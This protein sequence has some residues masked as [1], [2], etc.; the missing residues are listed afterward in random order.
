MAY[1]TNKTSMIIIYMI[2]PH[3][4]LKSPATGKI[5]TTGDFVLY[6]TKRNVSPHLALSILRYFILILTPCL[7]FYI[8]KLYRAECVDESTCKTTIGYQWY[9]EVYGSTAYL[10]AVG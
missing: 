8:F 6:H 9:I 10:V 4:R 3:K 7:D 1:M 2:T 5:P